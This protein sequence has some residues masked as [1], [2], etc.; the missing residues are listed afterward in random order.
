MPCCDSGLPVLRARLR[1]GG[2]ATLASVVPVDMWWQPC[3]LLL[4][5]GVLP[6][7][8]RRYWLV[9]GGNLCGNNVNM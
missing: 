9:G 4:I 2:C 3:S 7:D 6:E 5:M 8:A 1:K